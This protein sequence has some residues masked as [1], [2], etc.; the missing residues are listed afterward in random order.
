MAVQPRHIPEAEFQ[1][2]APA[3]FLD[4]LCEFETAPLE[5]ERLATDPR[6]ISEILQRRLRMTEIVAF[7]VPSAE[8]GERL[9]VF[10]GRPG[11]TS[12]T[13][14]LRA[15]KR[16]LQEHIGENAAHS[17]DVVVMNALPRTRSGH[18]MHRILH[19]MAQTRARVCN[20]SQYAG[21]RY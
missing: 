18:V 7:V 15:A 5:T 2:S 14:L 13:S 4:W 10:L 19:Q 6:S 11:L 9:V 16:E 21:A 17:A 12:R 3:R 8:R 1:G 20:K